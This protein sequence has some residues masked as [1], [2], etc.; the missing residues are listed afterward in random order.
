ME[1]KMENGKYLDLIKGH[2][3]RKCFSHFYIEAV[4][5]DGSSEALNTECPACK[6]TLYY[7]PP[8]STRDGSPVL[9]RI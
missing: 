9:S 5:R 1:V 3:C 8:G 7:V 2:T 6:S 4:F